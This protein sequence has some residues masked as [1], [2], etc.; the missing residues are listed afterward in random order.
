MARAPSSSYSFFET[1]IFLKVSSEARMEPLGRKRQAREQPG[2]GP[3]L[4][5]VQTPV[6][7]LQSSSTCSFSEQTA[8]APETQSIRFPSALGPYQFICQS[9]TV[10]ICST[11]EPK[12]G[13][14][15]RQRRYS[16][17]PYTGQ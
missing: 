16:T 6:R 7:P 11:G 8:P 15:E 10:P 5:R 12:P 2:T 14:Q 17:A 3:Q 13:S 1:H 9:G 4:S